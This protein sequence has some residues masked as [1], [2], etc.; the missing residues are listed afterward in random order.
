M[1]QWVRG[2][3][4][5]SR[6]FQDNKL[7]LD[8]FTQELGLIRG[9]FR[10]NKKEARVTPGPFLFYECFVSGRGEL[11][12]I[13]KVEASGAAAQ[14]SGTSLYSAFYIHEIMER[15]LPFHLPLP[16]LFQLYQWLLQGFIT[17]LPLAP[18]L[19]RFEAG[20]FHELGNEVPLAA[21]S[22]GEP[23][24]PQQIYQLDGQHGLRP[25]FGEQPK[26]KPLIFVEGA[27]ASAYVAGLWSDP[28]VL[29]M[30]K[31]LHRIWLDQL[32]GKPINARKLLPQQPYQ[33]ERLWQVPLFRY[34]VIGV[35]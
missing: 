22:R 20:L 33:G 11:K 10:R 15:L 7:L 2:Y 25:Y 5:H 1:A 6:P 34:P 13:Q 19:R 28:L 9:V 27:V 26:V 24:Q 4:L 3:V 30:G 8:I 35:N 14:L 21:T 18:I 17:G 29:L 31:E 32:L 16:E 12:T 23:L